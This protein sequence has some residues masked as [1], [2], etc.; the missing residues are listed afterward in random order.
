MAKVSTFEELRIW[1]EARVLV[2]DIYKDFSPAT[3]GG[4][5]YGVAGQVQ[6]AGVS[7]MNNIAE[8]FERS[9]D[10]EFAR[11]LDIAKGSCGEVRS[12]Y[13]T[14]EDLCYVEEAVAA[15]RRD[16]ARSIAKGIAALASHLRLST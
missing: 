15:Q 10:T 12:L 4:R 5:D 9:R 7:I 13:Y 8:G 6:R 1:Q 16:Q 2:K 14:A 11:F 3:S